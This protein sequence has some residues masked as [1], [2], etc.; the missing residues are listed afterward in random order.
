MKIRFPSLLAALCLIGLFLSACSGPA[1][2]AQ[3]PAVQAPA[4][5]PSHTSGIKRLV[6]GADK[7]VEKLN[8]ILNDEHDVDSMLFRGLTRTTSDNEVAPDI[9][10]S[11]TISDDQLTYT[12]K[13]RTDARWDDGQPVTAEDV[14]FTLDTLLN[15][16]TNSP[17]SGD[18]TEVRQVDVLSA[19]Q[20][21]I[22]LAH[23][24]PPL[25]HKLKLGLIPKHVLEGSDI[26]TSDFNRKPVGNGPFKLRE[27]GADKTI[28]LMRSDSYYGTKAKLDEIIVRPVPDPNTRLLQLK[29]GEL[30]LAFVELNQR[31]SVKEQ[32][33]FRIMQMKTVDYRGMLYNFRNPLFEDARVR[34]AISAAID[35]EA[36]VQG[37][38]FGHGEPAYGPLQKSWANFPYPEGGEYR[39]E[40]AKRLL[41]EAGWTPGEDGILTKDGKRFEFEFVAPATDSVRVALVNAISTQL[42]AV[43]IS[44]IPKPLDWSAI[45]FDQVDTFMIAWGSEFDPDDH[46][47]PVFHSSQSADGVY[48]YGAYRNAEVDRLLTEARIEPYREKRR[49]LYGQ[50]QQALNEDPAF[51]YLVYIDALYGVSK[52]I[53]GVGDRALGHHGS[54]VLWNIEEWDMN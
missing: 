9:A 24:F 4:G 34:Q 25:L 17:I 22:T 19:D 44:V 21:R 27:W 12:F 23:P 28:E 37:V 32:D 15:P 36:L 16:Q 33:P 53:S 38:L 42:K 40:E 11:W 52:K 5:E 49:E 43:G 18:F 7:E 1:P 48:N 41:Q 10:L 30:D 39:L 31:D 26:H 50:F 46:T 51:A 45:H 47:Y 2:A 20:V 3:A 6:Y 13:L 8:P 35:R 29:T 54:G 14:K